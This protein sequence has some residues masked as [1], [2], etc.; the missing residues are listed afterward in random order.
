MNK[1][2]L[3]KEKKEKAHLITLVL[4]ALYFSL[5]EALIPKP[6]PWMKFGLA[7][8]STIIAIK[9]FGSKMGFKVFLLRV[10]I[11]A[12]VMGTLVTPSFVLSFSAGLM[13]TLLMI[14]LFKYRKYFSILAISSISAVV[15]NITQLVVAYFLLFKGINLYSK[16]IFFFVILFI[17]TGWISGIILGYLINKFEKNSN[18]FDNKFGGL[19]NEKKIFWN[20]WNKR[21]SK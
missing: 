13:S 4:L 7:N 20:R 1:L 10:V 9:N 14:F 11:Q 16:S 12:L 17:L 5:F 15:H 3:R 8:I 2:T 21:R 6:F 18:V 19:S